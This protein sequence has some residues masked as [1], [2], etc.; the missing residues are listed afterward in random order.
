MHTHTFELLAHGLTLFTAL[1][2]Y[3]DNVN[4]APVTMAKMYVSFSLVSSGKIGKKTR[5]KKK[6][7]KKTYVL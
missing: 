7:L 4:V 6:I 1:Y 2:I 5:R 3:N